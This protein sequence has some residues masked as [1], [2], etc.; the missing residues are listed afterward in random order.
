MRDGEA[1]HPRRAP[2]SGRVAVLVPAAGSG[3]RMGGIP[4]Q[5]RPLGGAPVL[6]QTLHAFARHPSVGALVVVAPP[7]EADAFERMLATHGLDAA[8]TPGGATRQASVGCGLAAVPEGTEIV[9]VHDAVRPFIAADRIAAVVDAVWGVGAAALAVPVADTLRR[10]DGG[11]FGE[12]VPREGL[13]RMQTP[14]GARLDWLREAH[15]AAARDGFT[16]T[17]EVQLLQRAGRAVAL[18]EGD[19]RNLKLT[20]PADWAL[21]EALWPRWAAAVGA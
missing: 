12:T 13:W 7:S 8:V 20:H 6:V 11:A 19:A 16:G 4:K 9:L 17:D 2:H 5:R 1:E 3:A 10:S 18:V 21:A 15:A 14:Q